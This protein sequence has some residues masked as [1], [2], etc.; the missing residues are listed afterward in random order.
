[1]LSNQEIKKISDLIENGTF[2]TIQMNISKLWE[3]YTLEKDLIL[4]VCNNQPF[5]GEIL[6]VYDKEL[7]LIKRFDTIAINYSHFN[8]N[9]IAMNNQKHF[10]MSI[11][12][13]IVITNLEFR[14][15]K[16][17]KEHEFRSFKKGCIGSGY[18]FGNEIRKVRIYTLDLTLVH[19][20]EFSFIVKKIEASD[21]AL[22]INGGKQTWFYS[23]AEG[24]KLIYKYEHSAPSCINVISNNFYEISTIDQRIWCYDHNGKFINEIE[25]DSLNKQIPISFELC[26]FYLDQKVF[27]YVPGTN[28]L[29]KFE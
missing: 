20:M 5:M 11:N 12:D 16:L 23:L 8:P 18:I 9:I 28:S 4:C 10:Y 6:L 25:L 17:F 13:N 24:F 2:E 29:L 22:C 27:M 7:N 26:M 14:V 15:E 19:T 21:S 1:M 3:V